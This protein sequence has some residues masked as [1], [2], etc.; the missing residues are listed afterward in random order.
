MWNA[1][2][3]RGKCTRFWWESPK[4]IDHLEDQGVGG[5]IEKRTAIANRSCYSLRSILKSQPVYRN[6]KIII[7]KTLS[8]LIEPDSSVSIMSGYGLDDQTIQVRSPAEA[9]GFFL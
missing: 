6:T 5:R 4:E 7:Y 3:R 2:E 8:R 9:K 1:W